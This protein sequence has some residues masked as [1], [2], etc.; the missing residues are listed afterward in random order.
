[1]QGAGVHVQLGCYG[2]TWIR[3]LGSRLGGLAKERGVLCLREGVQISE[4]RWKGCATFVRVHGKALWRGC[5]EARW[6]CVGG[7]K[8]EVGLGASESHKVHDG[9]RNRV[10]GKVGTEAWVVGLG[11]TWMGLERGKGWGTSEPR[12]GVVHEVGVGVGGDLGKARLS[13]A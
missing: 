3:V 2:A 9:K 13:H 5:S 6:G 12:L 11:G 1:M 10:G 4:A 8:E 7:L